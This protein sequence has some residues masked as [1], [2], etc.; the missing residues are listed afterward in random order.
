MAIKNIKK[1]FFAKQD[2]QYTDKLNEMIRNKA[3]EFYQKR[4]CVPGRDLD[5]WLEAERMVKQ[6]LRKNKLW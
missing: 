3:Y 6:E 4:G 1:Q 5:N 2:T